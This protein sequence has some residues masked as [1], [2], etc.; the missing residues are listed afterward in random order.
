MAAP[1]AA[2]A[3]AL[4]WSRR[5]ELTAGQVIS[6]L[7]ET[8]TDTGAPGFDLRTGWGRVDALRA[9]L[10]FDPAPDL[11]VQFA[12]PEAVVPGAAFTCTITYGNQGELPASGV[13]ISVT[14]SAGLDS[15]AELG[16]KVGDLPENTGPFT[17]TLPVTVTGTVTNTSDP[18][19]VTSTVRIAGEEEEARLRN[20]ISSASVQVR[21]PVHAG[22]FPGAA[23]VVVGQAVTFANLTTGAEPVTYQWDFGDGGTSQMEEPAHAYESP[24]VYTVTLTAAN[25]MGVDRAQGVVEVIPFS[26]SLFFPFAGQ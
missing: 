17:L 19:V 2:G 22:F 10:S 4:L 8:A 18:N 9:L 24:G 23:Q 3:A 21:M 6:A 13:A 26:F 14:L 1:H 16:W 5:P 20:N 15:A 25:D 12:A 11:W 7:I